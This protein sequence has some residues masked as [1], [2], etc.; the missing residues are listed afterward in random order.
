MYGCFQKY[1]KTTQ[2]SILIG[3]SII[4]HAFWGVFPLFLETSVSWLTGIFPNF[5]PDMILRVIKEIKWL[6]MFFFFFS[7]WFFLKYFS[8]FLSPPN[9]WRTFSPMLTCPYKKKNG[10]GKT[11]NSFRELRELVL[12]R[13]LFFVFAV[14]V[15]GFVAC[16]L[17][18]KRWH[19]WRLGL[20]WWEGRYWK[21]F[22]DVAGSYLEDHPS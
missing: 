19:S 14:F 5:I 12:G 7:R 17:L 8:Q 15:A 9:N 20:S 18:M 13:H 21:G 11:I 1:G 6:V 16:A 3:F 10:S 4:N 2:T 22:L